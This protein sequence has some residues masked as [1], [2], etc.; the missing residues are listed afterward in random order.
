VAE[1][2][3]GISTLG[4]GGNETVNPEV[5]TPA[6]SSSIWCL[7]VPVQPAADPECPNRRPGT[8]SPPL[9]QAVLQNFE[10]AKLE[11]SGR[12]AAGQFH[13]KFFNR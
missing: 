11:R 9:Q 4:E 3:S 7:L 6:E 8:A 5:R 1:R 13:T 10:D 2:E 12:A